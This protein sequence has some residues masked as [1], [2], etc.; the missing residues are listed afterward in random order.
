MGRRQFLQGVGACL[1]LP[2]LV[3]LKSSR[4]LA[5]T[6]EAAAKLGATATGA[7]LRTGFIY[8]PNGAIPASWW[9]KD[10]GKEF[11]LSRTRQPLESTRS[12]IQVLGG[13]NHKT[14]YGGPDG[15]GDH[16]RGGGTFLTGM[17]LKKSATD[18]RAG[19]SIDQI[20]ARKIGHLTRFPSLE[21]ACESARKSGA[22][23]S[24]YSCAYQFNMSWSSPT[25]PVAA[26]SNPRLVFERLFGAGSPGERQANL[27]RR[28]VEQKSILD[29][30]IEDARSMQRKLDSQDKRKLDQ[31][32]TSV[33]EV[34]NRIQKEESFG[35]VP[36]PSVESPS[37]IP[38]DY[39]E[40]IQMMFDMLALAF[41][42]DSTRVATFLMAHDGSNRS[43]DHI[44][45]SEGHHDLTHHQ[46][47]AEWVDKVADIDLWY[48]KQ[49]ARF[50]EKLQAMKDPDGNTVLHNSMIVY[51]SGNADGNRHTHDNL[52]VLL[53]GA[54]GGTL[55][56]GR[57]V[58]HGSL[59]MTNLFLS[60]ADRVGADDL[61]RFGDSTERLGNI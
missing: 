58:K 25:T 3:S 31:Y 40:Y 28:R 1:A 41:Q 57:Y 60:M 13:L 11:A 17:R 39:T 59:P 26:E 33:R 30:V 51:G 46:N 52:P 54:G 21:L 42:T 32:L 55:T 7:P 16:A 23:D 6:P 44:G 24:G 45:I 9:P 56:P 35:E 38:G 19:V 5:A 37:G 18:L 53:A 20:L 49:F 48:V 29:L 12:M 36:N 43:F 34:E 61:P 15:P 22:C 47:R 10:D 14:A 27:Q 8:F 50:L 4:L 2:A